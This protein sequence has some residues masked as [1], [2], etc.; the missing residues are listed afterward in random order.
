MARYL[1]FNKIKWIS[2]LDLLDYK[3]YQAL[4]ILKDEF[5]YKPYPHKHYESVFT[6]FYQGYILPYK[7]NVDKRKPHLSSL[8]MGGEMTRDEALERAAGIAYLSEAEMEADRRYFIKKMGWSEEK[9]RDYMGRGEKPH[10]DY[11]SEVRLYQNLL[12]LY[13]KFNLGVGR[14]RW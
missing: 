9:F 12:F 13:R 10:T 1:I 6:R 3:K 8:I 2:F 14:L 4:E 5:S 7:F 11:P